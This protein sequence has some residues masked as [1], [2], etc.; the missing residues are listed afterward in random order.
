M[1]G[2]GSRQCL[3]YPMPLY[4]RTESLLQ[5]YSAAVHCTHGAMGHIAPRNAPINPSEGMSVTRRKHPATLLCAG[6]RLDYVSPTTK[7]KSPTPER[8]RHRNERYHQNRTS[9]EIAMAVSM[10]QYSPRYNTS[11]DR[12]RVLSSGQQVHPA[13]SRVT[14]VTNGRRRRS[15]CVHVV[16]FKWV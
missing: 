9:I 8:S 11:R 1:P 7:P 12:C 4:A 15:S 5:Q 3:A 6:V 10:K 13:G 16:A 2:V 14:L